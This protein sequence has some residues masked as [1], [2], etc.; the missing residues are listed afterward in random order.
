MLNFGQSPAFATNWLI[1]GWS[2]R[3]AEP[4][5]SVGSRP[6]QKSATMYN[7]NNNYSG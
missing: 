5:G 1:S 2:H 4:V 7:N 6:D 3:P